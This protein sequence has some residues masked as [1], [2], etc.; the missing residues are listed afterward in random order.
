MFATEC[1]MMLVKELPGLL[2]IVVHY[3][4]ELAMYVISILS[5]VL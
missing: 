3:Y 4:Y 5:N 2:D 1:V